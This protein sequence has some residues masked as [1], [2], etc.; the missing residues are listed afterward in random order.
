M[1]KTPESKKEFLKLMTHISLSKLYPKSEDLTVLLEQIN[2]LKQSLDSFRP[3]QGI[4]IEKLNQYLDE[5][6]TYDST[7]I[8]GNTLTLQETALVLNKGITIGGKSLREHFEIV[9]HKEAID[10]IKE[11]VKKEEVFNKRVLLDIHHLILKNI[12]SQNVG[13]FRNIDVMIS[14]SAHKP[15]TFLQ[16]ENLINDYFEFYEQEKEDLNPVILAAE[17]HER[18]VTIH[19]F[20]DGNGRTARLVMNLILLK[21]GFP[22][23]NISSQNALR[24][25]YY[26]SLEIA[27]TEGNKEVFHKF[28]AKNVKDSLIK[29]LEIIAINGEENGK[30]EYFYNRVLELKLKL[31]SLK[32]A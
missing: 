24:D 12:D 2:D 27:Q 7:T 17:L 30:G 13:K 10:Y 23:V 20:I 22:I 15:P 31:D 21:E 32:R 18:L 19:P 14:G 4:H 16:V 3:L 28:I 6:F 8:E 5:V 9:N 25:A 26:K 11:I 1:E 29:Y